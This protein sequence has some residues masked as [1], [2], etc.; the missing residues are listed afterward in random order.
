[1]LSVE[2]K[3]AEIKGDDMS[4]ESEQRDRFDLWWDHYF[5]TAMQVSTDGGVRFA[6]A[7]NHRSVAKKAW[8]ESARQAAERLEELTAG[9]I[10]IPNCIGVVSMMGETAAT[11]SAQSIGIPEQTLSVKQ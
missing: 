4:D 6:L 11:Y 10:E 7:E 1:M 3:Q 2:E 8:M 9:M 5:K